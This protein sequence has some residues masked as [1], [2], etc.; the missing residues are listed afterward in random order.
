MLRIDARHSR[1][2]LIEAACGLIAERGGDGVSAREIADR[3]GVSS[4]TLY[5]HFDTKRELID[6]VSVD[7]WQRAAAWA[8]A[9]AQGRQALQEIVVVLDRFSRM[10]SND[11]RF[12]EAADLQV[13]V[14]PHAIAPVRVMFEQR[15][16]DLWAQARAAGRI[17]PW[18]EQRDV[19]E[20]VWAIRASERRVPMLATVIGG[21]VSPDEDVAALLADARGSA[22][23]GPRVPGPAGIT[24]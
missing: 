8:L 18:A 4:A 2:Q 9:R 14:T 21:F 17:R 12:I 3:A 1:A 19:M 5:R 23:R 11:A 7:R 15:F 22:A 24:A 20:L 6:A 13:G 16:G 10:V